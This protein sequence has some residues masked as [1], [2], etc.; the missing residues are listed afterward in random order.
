MQ[1]RGNRAIYIWLLAC[2]TTIAVSVNLSPWLNLA[3]LLIALI[4]VIRAPRRARQTLPIRLLLGMSL[5]VIAIR[6]GFRILFAQNQPTYDVALE[7]P[8]LQ[9]N[10][11]LG[12]IDFLGPITWHSLVQAIFD[13]VRLSAILVTFVAANLW[14]DSK[15]LLLRMRGRFFE[16]SMILV[17]ALNFVPQIIESA[18]RTREAA[19][20]RGIKYLSWADRLSSALD[21]A[22]E[23]SWLLA[24]YLEAKGFGSSRASVLDV[25]KD[26]ALELR[27]LTV[28][29][30][31][32]EPM[33]SSLNLSVQPGQMVL[34]TG[35]Q[36]S[37]KS[38]L[39]TELA[40]LGPLYQDTAISGSRW[41][42]SVEITQK[43]AHEL[44]G[45]IA[46]ASEKFD[47]QAIAETVRQELQF[48]ARLNGVTGDI[49]SVAEQAARATGLEHLLDT[50]TALLSN[51]KRMK[52]QIA[53]AAI[54]S[55]RFVI[56]DGLLSRLDHG[57][58][59]ET[60][61]FFRSRAR[62]SKT[63]FVIAEASE[64]LSPELAEQFDQIV[65]LKPTATAAPIQPRSVEEP[66][67]A[68]VATNLNVEFNGRKLLQIANFSAT[69]NRVLCITGKNAAGKSTLLRELFERFSQ[70]HQVALLPEF[71]D[72]LLLFSSVKAELDQAEAQ[73]LSSRKFLN[74]LG[75]VLDESLHPSDL[76]KAQRLALSLCTQLSRPSEILLLDEPSHAF[77]AETST[78]LVSLLR[79]LAH[80]RAVVVVSHDAALISAADQVLDLKD[81][82]LHEVRP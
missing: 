16:L 7:L 78:R 17:L 64:F 77:S 15:S 5:G 69:K 33:I 75:F 3:V 71:A 22:L 9:L 70:D 13:G 23:K 19:K 55:Q 47:Q 81:G 38:A 29:S 72:D 76:S 37:G 67:Q 28:G 74:R 24:E 62:Q 82:Q 26:A 46:Y 54:A 39:L 11:G 80:D 53:L 40:G 63:A 49:D 14:A 31:G 58:R 35:R 10:L 4:A 66:G 50:P 20:L 44:A 65:E 1:L 25:P 59:L 41:L 8:Q 30:P 34:I 51:G 43:P 61:K 68:F 12:P 79:Q 32:Y 18:K 2:L 6:I 57:S 21:D 60:I 36:G 27:S 48:V 45:L 56:L 73:N 42:G 52:L